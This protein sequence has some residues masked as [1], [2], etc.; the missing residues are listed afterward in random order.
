MHN[1]YGAKGM[2]NTETTVVCKFFEIY[3]TDG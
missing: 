1:S 3:N 2:Y